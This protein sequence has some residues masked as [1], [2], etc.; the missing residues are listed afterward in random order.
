MKKFFSKMSPR[1]II[2]SLALFGIFSFVGCASTPKLSPEG[3]SD[4][5]DVIIEVREMGET[6]SMMVGKTFYL[7]AA[8]AGASRLFPMQVTVRDP[9][10]VDHVT[11][12]RT[13]VSQ[14]NFIEFLR[15]CV[16][17]PV[18]FGIVIDNSVKNQIGFDE[19]STI[20]KLKAM[21]Q[22]IE[23]SSAYLMHGE[24]GQWTDITKLF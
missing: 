9:E 7:N 16:Q 21:I 18:N 14:D 4:Q 17:T 24:A 19:A 6:L 15:L 23:G 5:C 22:S 12:T 3:V 8:Q 1:F 20:E 2:L 10:N 11:P 13:I